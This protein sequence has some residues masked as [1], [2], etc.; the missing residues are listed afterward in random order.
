[1]AAVGAHNVPYPEE[2]R[3]PNGQCMT[4]D[5]QPIVTS[6]MPAISACGS[7]FP[8]G[9]WCINACFGWTVLAPNE[10]VA[11]THCGVVTGHIS[12]PGCHKVACFGYGERRVST[13]LQAVDLPATKILDSTGSP[14]LVSAIVN[15]RV[16]DAMQALYGVD[17]YHTYVCV[18]AGATL[19]TV[20]SNHSYN[21]LKA[22]TEAFNTELTRAAA[23]QLRATGVEII[24]MRLNELNYAPEIANAMLK[25]QAAG[26]LLE[27]RALI[28]N[29]AVGI[30]EDAIK[31][32]EAGGLVTMA[33]ADKVAI[34]KDLLIVTC[35]ETDATPTVNVGTRA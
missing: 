17:D 28:V 9:C 34:V 16:V 23:A 29:G 27:A 25:T 13:K 19:K 11:I 7:Y 12:E 15:F 6:P 1:M 26:A 10:E 31:Q 32:L 24:E 2:A 8:F 18:N 20:V 35:S 33:A 21:D 14:I 30:A 4:R 22:D 5:Y 3:A